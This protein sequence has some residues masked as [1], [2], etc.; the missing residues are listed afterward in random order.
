MV[1]Y[2]PL[3]MFLVACLVLL[4]GYPVAFTLGGTALAFAVVGIE[5]GYFDAAFLEALPS[6]LYGIMT[7]ETLIAVP[8]FVFM[9][10]MLER[11][12]V[13]EDLLVTMAA[14]FGPIRGGLGISVTLVGM[15]MAAST[16]IVGATV[17][18]M[19]LLSLP[20]MLRY[21]YDPALATG[22][23]CASGTLGQIIP[24]SIVLVLLGDVL[25]SAY[26]QAQ[27][28][29]GVWSP[30]TVSVGDLFVGA[31]IPGLLLVAFYLI[32]LLIVAY[33]KPESMPAIPESERETGAGL[34]LRVIK[35]LL[36]P[37]LLIIA[38]LG[39]ILKGVA[40]PTEAASV[41]AVGA[42]VLAA[43]RK[44]L[45]LSIMRDVM[46]STTLVS[47]MVFLILI[48]ASLFS[49]VF[50]GYGGDDLVAHLLDRLPGGVFASVLAVM[51][52]MFLLG[53][54]LDFIEITFVVVPIVGPILLGMGLDPVWLGVM[55][56]INL[57]TSFL[58]PP[59]GFALFYLRGV[60]PPEVTTT[61]I[62][63]GVGSFIVIQL[64]MLA[65]LA[66]QPQLATWLPSVVYGN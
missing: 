59:F 14:L 30:D 37:F 27:L 4:L 46:R 38:V 26:Q 33:L 52:L 64:L 2:I 16:G 60:A 32:Y 18:T 17:I 29:Q 31:L 10:V 66:W 50:R 53:F 22:T 24:P 62:Y 43:T 35:V 8:L 3:L 13:A 45:N 49:L 36:P 21:K 5:A 58:T 6:R 42:M 54:I 41:G 57:Q 7:N 12:K 23:I 19:G 56:A 34:W 40:T 47:S 1:E 28:D 55:I 51:V 61:H 48:G 63:R 9:G 15:L 25:S 65:L 11:S 44:R 20:T 39:S